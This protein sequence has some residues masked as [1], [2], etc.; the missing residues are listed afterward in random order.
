MINV[1]LT[2]LS[3]ARQRVGPPSDEA[4]SLSAQISSVLAS[5]SCISVESLTITPTLHWCVCSSFLFFFL[6][7]RKLTVGKGSITTAHGSAVVRLGNTSV[8]AGVSLETGPMKPSL[9]TSSTCV[10][11]SDQLVVFPV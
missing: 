1:E 11:V 5:S 2:P 7:V 4:Q 3:S 8:V 6:P 10:A 9:P